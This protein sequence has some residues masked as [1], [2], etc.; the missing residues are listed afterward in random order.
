MILKSISVPDFVA[1][2][3]QAPLR[4]INPA[5]HSVELSIDRVYRLINEA[6]DGLSKADWEVAQGLY[7]SQNILEPYCFS[8]IDDKFYIWIEERNAKQPI[9]IFKSRYLAADYFVWL[10]SQGNRKINWDLFM[11]SEP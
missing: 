9:A 3:F 5:P 7:R 8:G 4:H 2:Q 6:L 1:D 10:V 11:E